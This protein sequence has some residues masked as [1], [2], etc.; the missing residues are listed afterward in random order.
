ML[1][2]ICLADD[3]NVVVMEGHRV[4]VEG[5]QSGARSPLVITHN[6]K[7]VL[8]WSWPSVALSRRMKHDDRVAVV[9]AGHVWQRDELVV[10][11]ID[12][13]VLMWV[14]HQRN[15]QIHIEAPK[16][17][18]FD[19]EAFALSRG[20]EWLVGG[21]KSHL[22]IT[23][24]LIS[25]CVAQVV[26]LPTSCTD[27]FHP[28]FL[29]PIHPK[30]SQVLAVLNSTGV[31][32][33]ID[34]TSATKLKTIRSQRFN[35]DSVSVSDDGNFIAVTFANSTTKVYS[36][37]ALFPDDPKN[38]TVSQVAKEEVAFRIVE[39][40]EKEYREEEIK[41]EEKKE[42]SKEMQ[43]ILDK[44]KWYQI[45]QEFKGYPEKYRNLIW[46]SMLE[47][48]RN[49]SV[50]SSLLDKGTHTAFEGLQEVLQ[51]SD[52][53]LL[54]TL[55]GTL[56]CLAHWAPFLANV[57]YLPEFVFPFVKVFH[58]NPLLCFEVTVTIIMNW[59]RL[60]FEFWPKPG[61]TVLN[62]IEQIICEVNP[63]LLAH[64][65]KLRVTA[66]DYAWSLLTNAFSKVLCPGDWLVLWDHIL[67]NPPSFLPC[68]AAGFTLKSCQ[69]LLT[70]TDAHEIRI[71]YNQE[72]W[73]P[74][75]PLLN[76]AYFLHSQLSETHLPKKAFGT[77]TPLP[78]GGLPLFSIGPRDAREEEKK[79]LEKQ[80]RDLNLRTKS[81]SL[82]SRPA[83][84]RDQ[85]EDMVYVV[86]QKELQ[87]QEEEC[88]E[89]IANLRKRHL[90]A[91]LPDRKS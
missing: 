71:Y 86:G 52:G 72:S 27:I 18:H 62:V 80:L 10:S 43:E 68:V 30:F 13:S 45:L 60:W 16:G 33:I 34:F 4:P 11:F 3:G 17:I 2:T 31:L 7:E 53:S 51:L 84:S 73:V 26:Q 32:N 1:Y 57:E 29:P 40:M 88:L 91:T 54:K 8:L 66:E 89:S 79:D 90:A 77:F 38:I 28:V 85:Q 39:K 59:C 65:M 55:Q 37:R 46:I 69:T 19:F 82:Y 15:V 35:I 63:T 20:G 42:R 67:S 76:K 41:R 50:F 24:S 70:C 83:T 5:I 25:Q 81:S 47:V 61:L 44:N 74:V 21:G 48:P 12:G 56:S 36:V 9:W 58:S 14:T 78:R 22:L 64:L 6:S 87:K 75:K 49:Y 23:Y